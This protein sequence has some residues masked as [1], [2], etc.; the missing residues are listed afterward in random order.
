MRVYAGL[1]I[2]KD[3]SLLENCF[4]PYEQS[5]TKFS[6]IFKHKR[7]H[8]CHLIIPLLTLFVFNYT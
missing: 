1:P 6:V 7:I 2:F 8:F 3:V 4:H 5:Y